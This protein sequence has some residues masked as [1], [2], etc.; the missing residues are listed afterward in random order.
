MQMII[1]VN[2]VNILSFFLDEN[3]EFWGCL[4]IFMLMNLDSDKNFIKRKA[5]RVWN[6]VR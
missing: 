1:Y 2:L 5:N 3:P 4:I 6:N